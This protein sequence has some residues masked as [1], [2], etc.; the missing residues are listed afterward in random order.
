[1]SDLEDAL[2]YFD[3]PDFSDID[4]KDIFVLGDFIKTGNRVILCAVMLRI[5]SDNSNLKES[6]TELLYKISLMAGINDNIIDICCSQEER[7]KK[8]EMELKKIFTTD[9]T[10]NKH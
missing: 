1:M 4:D 7:I 8:I 2:K 10:A 9:K 5:L 3:I 6:V